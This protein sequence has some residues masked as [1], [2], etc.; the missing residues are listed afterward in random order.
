[1]DTPPPGRYLIIRSLESCSSKTTLVQGTETDSQA[2]LFLI[3]RIALT[4]YTAYF[5]GSGSPADTAAVVVAGFVAPVDQWV[6]FERNWNE[7]LKHFGVSALHMREFAHSR[8]EF[9]SWKGNETKRRHF[10][11]RLIT[12]I[13]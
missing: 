2:A 3:G 10:L 4:K 5:D 12:I 6:D 9:S 7:C 13:G 11:G 1:M 8:G